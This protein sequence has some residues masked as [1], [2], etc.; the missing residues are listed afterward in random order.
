METPQG[1][2]LKSPRLKQ[3]RRRERINHSLL[4]P[5]SLEE[6][7][8]R[9][10]TAEVGT[11]RVAAMSRELTSKRR[12]QL[13]RSTRLKLLLWWLP[14]KRHNTKPVRLMLTMPRRRVWILGVV[15]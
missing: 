2:Q 9:A 11:V 12:R 14:L 4:L 5:L 10:R 6:L 1:R 7:A 8:A 13:L 3:L 15:A